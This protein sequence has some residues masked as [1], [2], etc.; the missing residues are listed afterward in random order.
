MEG[1]IR[2]MCFLVVYLQYIEWAITINNPTVNVTNQPFQSNIKNGP[3]QMLLYQ[4]QIISGKD[5]LLREF[6]MIRD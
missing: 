4:Y 1:P 6:S 3:M 2:I 5:D